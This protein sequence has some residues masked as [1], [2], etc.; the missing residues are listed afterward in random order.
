MFKKILG[1]SLLTFEELSTILSEVEL[2]LNSRPLT[3]VYSDSN[4]PEPLSPAHFLNFGKIDFKF[5]LYFAELFTES[6]M[7]SS[8]I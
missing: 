1:K 7:R 5:P 3:Y 2:V 4:E 6:S 8:L